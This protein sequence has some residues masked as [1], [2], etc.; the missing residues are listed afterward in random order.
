[1]K[2]V[3]IVSAVFTAV[4][5]GLVGYA[6]WGEDE[7]TQITTE[8]I[9]AQGSQGKVVEGNNKSATPASIKTDST[10][11]FESP[12]VTTAKPMSN[13]AVLQWDQTAGQGDVEVSFRTHDGQKWSEWVD[14]ESD[15]DG[16]DNAAPS[17]AALVLAKSIAKIQYRFTLHGK[18][19]GMSPEV[20]V[21][22][23]KIE[24]I[25]STKGP[26]PTKKNHIKE[27]VRHLFDGKKAVARAD[28][29]SIYT[30]AEWGSPEPN[31]SANWEPEYETLHRAV[32]HHTAT[33][34]DGDPAASIRAIWHFHTYTRGW[35]DIGYNYL[36]D[37]AGNIYQ[38]RYFDPNYVEQ[39][40]KDVV[41]G[42]ALTWNY[43]STGIASIADYSG[44]NRPSERVLRS[45]G[46]IIA[47]KLHRYGI[48]PGG[49]YGEYPVVVGHKDVLQ[50]ACPGG[51]H[52]D[53]ASIRAFAS[54]AYDP[55]FIIDHFDAV[56]RSQGVNGQPQPVLQMNAGDT[57]NVY[58]DYRNDGIETWQ[59]SGDNPVRIATKNPYGR[60]SPFAAQ[61]WA[62][63]SRPGAFTHRVTS[64][65][66]DGTANLQTATEIL[67]GQTARFTF[68]LKAPETGG[69][70]YEFFQ[71]VAEGKYWFPRDVNAHF[72]I[73]VTPRDFSWKTVSQI[74]YT[75]DSKSTVVANGPMLY[76]L[77]AGQR[78]FI[79]LKVKN[80]GNQTWR[81]NGSNPMR[82][83]ITAPNNQNSAVC[84]STW[85]NCWRAATLK[86]ATITPGQTGTFEFW[87][88]MP[89]H[90]QNMRIIEPY[91][92]VAEALAWAPPQPLR[93]E[94]F[95]DAEILSA[96]Y[97]G[98][99]AYTDDSLATPVNL[100][101]VAK[102]QRFYVVMQFKNVGNVTWRPTGLRNVRLGTQSP[103][104]ASAFCDSTWVTQ[105][106]RI[107]AVQ[108]STVAPGQTGTFSFW[109]QAPGTAGAYN[110]GFS[111]VSEGFSWFNSQPANVQITIVP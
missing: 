13:A 64:Y 83:G 110:E 102:N 2:K 10:V 54:Q 30:R 50:T 4:I 5:A 8:T 62:H 21:A 49:Y 108:Q 22:D 37:A 44:N 47:F 7:K 95:I 101:N 99:Q 9:S 40:R 79:E 38:G 87:T 67:P 81:N 61:S 90:T 57:A 14:S 80:E 42:H 88:E 29:P 26:S 12:E 25:D 76:N 100:Q 60:S 96:Q 48:P 35:G 43:G 19:A 91:N 70:Y 41:G 82:L 97:Q 72:K 63:P 16:K 73:D 46:D 20:N 31:S 66:P 107:G 27:F 85:I 36:V 58:F 111:L 74:A 104:N 52:N 39:N 92:L 6:F 59:N 53:L 56:F 78:Y 24:L 51:M 18:D 75:N 15:A 89:Y 17:Y 55:Y 45:I 77:R 98:I 28:G 106:N 65:N 3:A 105:C 23:A 32:V 103:H 84:D 94:F 109:M 1:M 34:A 71:P 68:T 93:W 11:T 69:T 33:T 86:E